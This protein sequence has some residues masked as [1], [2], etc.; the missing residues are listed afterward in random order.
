LKAGGP[1]YIA[2]FISAEDRP[3]A[4]ETTLPDDSPLALLADAVR[5][6]T[7]FPERARIIATLH[8]YE[9]WWHA[10]FSRAHDHFLLLGEDNFR[11][12]LPLRVVRVRVHRDDSP[13]EIFARVAAARRTGARVVV[14]APCDHDNEWIVS[15]ERITERWAGAIEFV[16][17][18]DADVAASMTNVFDERVR[19]GCARRVPD[20]VRR[21]AAEHGIYVADAPVV[22]DGRMELLWYLREQSISDAYHRYGNLGVRAGEPRAEPL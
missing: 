8:S 21:A 22:A 15:L 14:S 7:H 17:E 13:F 4:R 9:E 6:M 18:E 3:S 10:E 5:S 1:N 11:R 12:Y 20:L 19:F 2:Q 16:E